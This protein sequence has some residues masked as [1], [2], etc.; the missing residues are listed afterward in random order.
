[1]QGFHAYSGVADLLARK[2]R[3]VILQF[4]PKLLNNIELDTVVECPR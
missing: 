3:L 4:W 1:M 2:L